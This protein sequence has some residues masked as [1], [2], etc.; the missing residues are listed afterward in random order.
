MRCTTVATLAR[1]VEESRQRGAASEAFK[2]L[3]E[4][5]EDYLK[6]SM[7]SGLEIPAWLRTLEEEVNRIQQTG[8]ANSVDQETLIRLGES[9]LNLRELR[10]QLRTWQ[11]PLTPRSS[12][13]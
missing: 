4:L 1:A 9:P 10:L 12:K 2:S 11:Q 7:G 8:D 3:V 5:A 13:S 6:T